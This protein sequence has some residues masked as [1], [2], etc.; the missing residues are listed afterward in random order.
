MITRYKF[1]DNSAVYFTTSTAIGWTDVFIRELYKIILLDNIGHC[2]QSLG[3]KIY[4]WVLM[5]NHLHTIC[6]C[7]GG[8]DLGLI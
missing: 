5:T 4:A 3:L 2:Q 6:N 7:A 1:V 8:K